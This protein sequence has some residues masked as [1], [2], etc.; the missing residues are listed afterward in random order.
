MT[1]KELSRYYHLKKEIKDLE[2]RIDEIGYGLGATKIKEVIT[3]PGVTESIQQKIVE[4]RDKYVELRLSA[5][6][7]YIKIENFI[8][9]IEDSD[10][11][12]MMR[13]RF[14]SLKSWERI[15]IEFYCDR[16]TVSKKVRRYLKELSHNSH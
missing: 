12:T 14:L 7:E 13:M 15:G 4:L 8:D 6:E 16:T 5:L 1:E 11:R 9:T 2:D 10:I 3:N